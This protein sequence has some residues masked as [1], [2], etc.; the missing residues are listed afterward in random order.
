MSCVTLRVRNWQGPAGPWNDVWDPRKQCLPGLERRV[1]G[2]TA[3]AVITR[4]AQLKTPGEGKLTRQPCGFVGTN[5][6]LVIRHLANPTCAPVVA[7]TPCLLVKLILK[8]MGISKTEGEWSM[9][10]PSDGS[11]TCRTQGAH[12]ALSEQCTRVC[13]EGRFNNIAL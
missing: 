6:G 10:H 4:D 2:Q 7:L 9:A 13:R 3:E 11:I 1:Q 5:P 8:E 12:G